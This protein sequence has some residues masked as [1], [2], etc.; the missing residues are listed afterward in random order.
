MRKEYG[1][2]LRSLFEKAMSQH[3]PDFIPT[4]V[5]SDYVFP[6]ERTFRKRVEGIADLWIVLSPSQ[7]ME[8]FS[9]ELG[10]SRLA[11]FPEL[12]MRPSLQ[13]PYEAFDETEYMCR[14]GEL[15]FGKDHWWVVEKFQAPSN[16]ED[17][18]ASLEKLSGPLA[19]E[20]V[21][22]RVD[23]AVGT[24]IEKGIPYL[25]GA[26]AKLSSADTNRAASS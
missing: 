8:E 17:L 18:A 19:I 23:E 11:R 20:R 2:A 3:L 9:I 14:L 26:I 1:Q 6:G 12:V 10:W 4:K 22:P 25:E 16:M 5:A 21:K 15:A 7:R 13:Q 24:L